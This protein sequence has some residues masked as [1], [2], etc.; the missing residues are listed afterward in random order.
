MTTVRIKK[1]VVA[2]GLSYSVGVKPAYVEGRIEKNTK[3][4]AQILEECR[5]YMC[6]YTGEYYRIAGTQPENKT[7]EK[8]LRTDRLPEFV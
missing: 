5:R 6:T 7:E 3:Y 4:R 1:C 2:R 8:R